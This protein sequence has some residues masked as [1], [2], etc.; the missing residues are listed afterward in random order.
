MGMSSFRL[1]NIGSL[2]LVLQGFRKLK[3]GQESW[4]RFGKIN[5]RCCQSFGNKPISGQ[6]QL[7]KALPWQNLKKAHSLLQR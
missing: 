4:Q 3:F 7:A 1:A 5:V 6:K 2:S